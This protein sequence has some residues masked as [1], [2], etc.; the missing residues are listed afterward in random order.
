[1][2]LPK[3]QLKLPRLSE[4]PWIFKQ[5]LNPVEPIP[6]GSVAD[7]VDTQGNFLARGFYN[8]HARI[9]FRVLTRE[10][11]QAIDASFVTKTLD[12]AYQ[13]RLS[14]RPDLKARDHKVAFRLCNGEGDGFSGL[15]VD[16]YDKLAVLQ[17]YAAGAN[18]L[19]QLII[20]EL[21][22]NF[23]IEDFYW[24]AERNVQKQE[25]FDCRYPARDL[26]QTTIIE[27]GLIF[28][29]AVSLHHKT[30]FFLDQYRNRQ[31]LAQFCVAKRVLDLC[32]FTGGFAVHAARVAK[33]VTAVDLDPLATE[34][35]RINAALNDLTIDAVTADIYEWLPQHAD[36]RYDVVILDPAKLTK[37]ADRK[38]QA[39]SQYTKL[40]TLAINVVAPGGILLS[41]SCSGLVSESEF[42]DAIRRAGIHAGRCLQI[43]RIS[44]AAEDHPYLT[45]AQSGRYLKAVW[46][47]VW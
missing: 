20:D 5:H 42:I 1:M 10:H 17:F 4:H 7:L 46:I 34:A 19:R 23:G 35:V 6:N 2:T 22:T 24:F 37:S 31:S 39:L 32:C 14:V 16:I 12:R 30:G 18:R 3:V 9:G 38:E 33:T 26:P 11:I 44:G 28:K 45:D 15:V 13:L 8:G 47:R 21:R 25:S 43:F 27:D 40:N 41:C 36:E 29:V